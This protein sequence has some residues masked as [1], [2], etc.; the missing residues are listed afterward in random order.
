[1]CYSPSLSLQVC[2]LLSVIPLATMCFH[3]YVHY[4]SEEHDSRPLS[5]LNPVTAYVARNPYS[6]RKYEPCRYLC[7]TEDIDPVYYCSWHKA[8]CRLLVD[9]YRCASPVP[10]QCPN[11][12]PYHHYETFEAE[13]QCR[14]EFE[15]FVNESPWFVALRNDVFRVGEELWLIQQ[16]IEK[17]ESRLHTQAGDREKSLNARRELVNVEARFDIMAL[18]LGQLARIWDLNHEKGL[19]SPRPGRHA[20][21]DLAGYETEDMFLKVHGS[22]VPDDGRM[23]WPKWVAITDRGVLSV[24]AMRSSRTKVPLP[25]NM[26]ERHYPPK[27]GRVGV[28]L[29][30]RVV[31]RMSIPATSFNPPPLDA[32]VM[33]MALPDPF[34]QIR[35]TVETGLMGRRRSRVS[36]P[37]DEDTPIPIGVKFRQPFRVR[38]RSLRTEKRI[39]AA[40]EYVSVSPK[41]K[42]RYIIPSAGLGEE[43][44]EEPTVAMGSKETCSDGRRR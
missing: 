31:S 37:E 21:P 22:A 4:T 38:K 40:R 15:H 2:T 27:L 43:V 16:E 32:E 9:E 24:A 13:D 28:S 18:Y 7:I 20:D 41:T 6:E 35:S 42:V 25:A 1:M 23:K 33:T 5:L 3:L 26:L 36:I 10:E 39:A 14:D 8:C 30:G 11:R 29:R 17:K 12:T 19:S 44:K 34:G